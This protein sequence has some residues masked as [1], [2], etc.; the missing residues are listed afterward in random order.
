VDGDLSAYPFADDCSRYED[1]LFTTAAGGCPSFIVATGSS[2]GNPRYP[3][4]DVERGLTVGIM[5]YSG[6]F[7][8][9]HMFKVV[10][11]KVSRIH[12]MMT[13]QNAGTTGW[14]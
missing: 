14:D 12:A 6:I 11:G 2:L 3:V 5:F 8:D 9:I 4:I 10:D 13:S 1:G 7:Y